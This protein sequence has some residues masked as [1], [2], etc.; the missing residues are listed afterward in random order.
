MKSNAV[1]NKAEVRSF[2]RAVS[3]EFIQ[4][5]GGYAVKA[6][7]GQKE[8]AKGWD[9][10]MNNEAKS[11]QLLSQ[12]EHSDDNIGIHLHG[13][14]VDVDIDSDGGFIMPALDMLLPDCPHIWG[15]TKRPKTH[16]AYVIKSST[17]F[18]PANYSILTRIKRI[19]EVKV[20]IRG[21]PASRGE[22]SLLPSSTH[23]DDDEY[24]WH[25]I[26]KARSTPTVVDLEIL[27]RR[28]R[29]AGAIAVVA[30][31][32]NEG[33]RQEMAM[34]LA[35]FIHRASSISK[36]ISEDAYYL[37]E[38]DS[39]NFLNTLMEVTGDD[40][41]DKAA[42]RKAFMATWAKAERGLPV[43]GATRMAELSGDDEIVKKM[44]WLLSENANSVAIDE[45]TSRFAIWQGPALVVD[46]EL[47]S[48]GV[49]KPLM[50]R[51]NFA[52]SFAHKTV[53]IDD[54]KILLPELLWGLG[55]AIR[56][57]GLTFDPEGEQIVNTPE[58]DKMNQWA[59]FAIEPAASPVK[60]ADVKPFLHYL[61]NVV[62]DGNDSH[63][64]WVLSWVADIF[65]EPAKKCGT[66]LVL[67]GLPGA[68]KSI[69]GHQILGRIIGDAHYAST[70][71]VDNV[72]KN[73]NVAF[74]NRLLI[75]CDEAMNSRQKAIAARLKSLIT[76]PL[77][78]VEPKGVDSY[79]VPLHARML[80]TSNDVED[81]LY[82]NDGVDDRRYTVLEVSARYKNQV[83]EYWHPL[84]KW[85]N[86]PD[87]LA[88][89]HRYL[90]DFKYDKLA[91]QRPLQTEAKNTMQQNS[92]DIFDGW[93]AAMVARDFPLSE[94]CH[95]H[96]YDAICDMDKKI[97][98]HQWPRLVNMAAM[99][100]CYAR[101][102]R[103]VGRQD[104]GMNE[105]HM[106]MA[107]KRRG[108][109]LSEEGKKLAIEEMDLKKNMMVKKRVRVYP[110][111]DKARI[112]DYLRH[113]Y[114]FNTT[115]AIVDTILDTSEEKEEY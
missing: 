90:L 8:P 89:I 75:Q 109:R 88:A 43:T 65:K 64:G 74:S 4:N 67:V 3:L 78:M 97:V 93:L 7:R 20:E 96:W 100:N 55:A 91:I 23:P 40:E 110:P 36:S 10:R 99:T 22:Y 103:K 24:V 41:S 108:L 70:N 86:K 52:S 83:K 12:L 47:A 1:P 113:K 53:R 102:Q 13:A 27:L 104:K 32:W 33:T 29:Q 66:A 101:F 45:F 6:I 51:R 61:Y 94:A 98:R 15:R 60:K 5:S 48:K 50:T 28:V 85:L 72:T 31:Y 11:A 62:C 68:G 84:V 87:S 16:R 56:V 42:R 25:D 19:P 54:K 107:L 73:F 95:E 82:L 79:F 114:G 63:Y 21:G 26:G 69:L 30:P 39:L 106:S 59:G 18:D 105:V 80:F 111:P 46:M 58:G 57:Q 9:P 92:W 49:A 38:D 34:A 35:G 112:L 17:T 115:D 2:Q 71:S 14:L 77:Q 44:Y 81:A 76:D 37:D